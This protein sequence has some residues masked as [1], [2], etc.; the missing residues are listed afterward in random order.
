MAMTK[1]EKIL[2]EIISVKERRSVV[3]MLQKRTSE[4][5]QANNY[6]DARTYAQMLV[7]RGDAW[8]MYN[9]G[10]MLHH[11][12]G[13]AVDLV[14]ARNWYLEA[15]NKRYASAM[16]NYGYMLQHGLGGATD[17]VDARKWYLDAANREYV[18]A[19]YNY[20]VLLERGQGGDADLVGAR[21]WY[22]EAA[23]KGDDFAKLNLFV[24]CKHGKGGEIDIGQVQ[25]WVQAVETEEIKKY[26]HACK[27]LHKRYALELLEERKDSGAMVEL[28]DML[29]HGDDE[30][31]D[32]DKAKEV[33]HRWSIKS[34]CDNHKET[35][36]NLWREINITSMGVKGENK[37]RKSD[38]EPL[39]KQARLG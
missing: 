1:Q 36:G 32:I 24:L 27:S 15:A 35:Y 33:V 11:G 4:L 20:G 14:G 13:G 10:C 2:W 28:V 9:Y 12:L 17:L 7:D 23:N 29:L 39:A 18:Y 6:I 38:G 26:A 37:K 3:H 19:M 21:K 22:L 16:N 31:K 8:G 30:V 5:Y 25:D 34:V